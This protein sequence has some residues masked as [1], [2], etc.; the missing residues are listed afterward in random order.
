M[1]K[2]R[3]VFAKELMLVMCGSLEMSGAVCRK[4]GPASRRLPSFS[5]FQTH[6][7]VEGR[8]REEVREARQSTEVRMG[9]VQE[10]QEERIEAFPG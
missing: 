1:K 10:T 6:F 7:P 9:A 4:E 3:K 5:A 2:K 8:N